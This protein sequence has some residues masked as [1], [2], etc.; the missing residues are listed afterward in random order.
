MA[1][2]TTHV[3]NVGDFYSQHYLDAVLPEDLQPV[4]AA[5]SARE[6]DGGARAPAKLLAR[7][8]EPYFKALAAFQSAVDD[9]DTRV[10][11]CASFHAQVLEALGYQRAP[12]VRALPDDTELPLTLAIDLHGRP[13]LWVIELPFPESEDEADP[14]AALPL[15]WLAGLEPNEPDDPEQSAPRASIREL[16]DG[17]L[18]RQDE[19]PR[20]VL[21]LAGPDVFLVDRDKWPQGQH[22]HFALGEMLGQRKAAALRAAVGLLHREVL[23]PEGGRSLLDQIDEKSHKHAF[24]VSTDLK[25]GVQKAIELIGNEAVYYKGKVSKEKLY[26]R[27]E[28]AS[29]LANDCVTYLYRLLFLFYVEARG[30]DMGIVPMNADA[31]RLGLSVESLRDLELIPLNTE[32]AREGFFIHH[33]LQKLFEVVHLGWPVKRQR[34]IKATYADAVDLTVVAQRSPLFDQARTPFDRDRTPIL[35]SVKLRNVVLQQVIALLSLSKPGDTS[36]GRGQRGRISYAQLG[37]NQLGAVYEGLLSYTGFFT[38]EDTF[39]VQ[40]PKDKADDARVFYVGRSAAGDYADDEFRKTESGKKIHH[41]KGTFLFRLA[42][43]DREKSASFY[44]PEVLTKCLTKYT[45]KERLGQPGPGPSADPGE[46]GSAGLSATEILQLTVCEPAMGSGA[47]LNEAVSQLAH[48]YLERRQA[49]LDQLI[50]AEDYQREWLRVKYHFVVNNCYGVDLNPLAAELGKVSLWLGV[51]QPGVEAPYLDPRIK[52]GNSLIGARRAV[53]APEDLLRKPNKK[54]GAVNWLGLVPKRVAPGEARPA[55][56]IYHFLVPDEAMAPYEKDKVVKKLWSEQIGEL[57]AWRKAACKPFSKGEVARLQA[58]SDA[59]DQLWGIHVE[60]RGSVLERVRQPIQLWGQPEIQAGPDSRWKTIEECELIGQA[61]QRAG[62]AGRRLRAVMDYWCELWSWSLDDVKGLPSREAWAD[63]VEAMLTGREVPV[64]A[65]RYLHWELEFAEVFAG[66]GGFDVILGNPPWI[67]LEWKEAGILGDLR[68]TMELRKLSAKQVADERDEA[69]G[70]AAARAGYVAEFC[71]MMGG[72]GFLNAV[73]NY[74]LLAGVQT[75]LYKCFLSAG[76][77]RLSSSGV[78][79]LFHQAGVFDDPK[80]GALRTELTGRGFLLARLRNELMLFPE[81]GHQ[82]PYAFSTSGG[83]FRPGVLLVS[84]LLHP[85]TLESSF[86]H[87]GYGPVPGFKTTE[88]NWDLRPHASRLVKVDEQ[89]LALFAKLYDAHGTPASQA[90]LPVVHSREMLSVLRRFADAP[91]KLSDEAGNYFCTV[92]F[93]ETGRQR[94]G[95]IRREVR[96]PDKLGEWVV[97]GPH[98]YVGTPFN[99]TPNEGCATKG[100]YSAIDLT[101]I[102]EDYLPRTNY[103]P[104]CS[105]AEYRKRT[106]TWNGRPVTEYF[107]YVH[108]RMLAPT[109]ERTLIPALVPPGAAHVHTVLSLTAEEPLVVLLAGMGASLPADFFFKTTGKNDLYAEAL[110][111]IPLPVVQIANAMTTRSLFLNA[112]SSAYA[113]LWDRNLPKTLLPSA[114]PDP[115]TANWQT[116]P[117]K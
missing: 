86:E 26:D 29:E 73:G 42:G 105:P 89:A 37:I 15:A 116:S 5:W 40:N 94:D 70:S 84:N 8:A 101:Q 32:R 92:C 108:R 36:R 33:S 91:R 64:I 112:L 38:Q 59:I 7:L 97:S 81:I 31:Y 13:F 117:R 61:T 110:S 68:P 14:L 82:R 24:A 76:W 67:K 107:R 34:D 46:P 1:I 87:D 66:R 77:E 2:D 41:P 102:S 69:L 104:A 49:E 52:V 109:G 48:A 23:L 25:F 30:G 54:T 99:K 74:P 96:F 45:L 27:P 44:T 6:K 103:V 83:V 39:E 79:G 72:L 98:I 10:G 43:R 62:S 11:V 56:H 12:V 16:L 78:Q 65:G 93:D 17:P 114:K 9:P 90:R 53:Y 3:H 18:L 55:G 51:L 80:G 113:P 20:W 95:T 19:P 22:L 35:S 106:P 50:P 57:K 21:L 28:L 88:G 4:F 111:L 85:S 63:K 115:R 47:F 58:L 60:Q 75:N 100:D 71:Q